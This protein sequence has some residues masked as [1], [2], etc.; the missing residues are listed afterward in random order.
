[1][2]DKPDNTGIRKETKKILK[3]RAAYY[4]LSTVD[5]LDIVL[6]DYFEVNQQGNLNETRII[7]KRNDGADVED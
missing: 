6:N 7:K 4:G 2:K 5:Y 1:M 3:M